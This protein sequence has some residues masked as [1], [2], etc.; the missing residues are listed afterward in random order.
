MTRETPESD[1]REPTVAGIVLAAGSGSR[2][3]GDNKLLAE[4]D[5]DPVIERAVSRMCHPRVDD[6][7]VVLGH[8][9][10]RI[11]E[12]IGH[13]P[14]RIVENERYRAG[15]STS[16]QCGLSAIDPSTDAVVIALGDMPFVRSES[17]DT[18]IDAYRRGVGDALA[19]AYEG[20]RGNPVLF[21][22]RYIESLREVEGDR[23]GRRLLVER[24]ELVEVDDPGVRF[25]IDTREDIDEAVERGSL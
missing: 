9:R 17:I 20:T 6:V 7:V 5:G 16:L 4:V 22:S 10:D 23:G 3:E 25:D 2:F 13:L 14:V 18:L 12:V 24:G 1:D 8:D 11:R 15:Q 19:L 21:D